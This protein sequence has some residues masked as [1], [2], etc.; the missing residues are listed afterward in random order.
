MERPIKKSSSGNDP[1]W[2]SRGWN[3]AGAVTDPL[4]AHSGRARAILDQC[5]REA[6]S[7]GRLGLAL[8][9]LA[10]ETSGEVFWTVLCEIWCSSD[11]T[12]NHQEQLHLALV[13][14]ARTGRRN[15][16]AGMRPPEAWPSYVKVWRGCS[17]ERVMSV[18]W[19]LNRTVAEEFALGY[20]GIEIPRP[21]LASADIHKTAIYF[22]EDERQEQE[23]VLDPSELRSV[24]VQDI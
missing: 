17:R 19:T 11:N 10:H 15:I 1:L 7:T 20:R 6:D 12:W 8:D 21:V 14:H 18:S 22:V 3:E 4:S 9:L 16:P 2:P 23:V 13:L 24:V 5:Y